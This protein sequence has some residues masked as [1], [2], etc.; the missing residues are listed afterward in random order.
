MEPEKRHPVRLAAQVFFFAV[1]LA[2]L[3]YA[4][5]RL[6][7]PITRLL[8]NPESFRRFL[9]RYGPISAL[10]YV[11][12]QVAQVVI[13]VIPGEVVQIAGGY[14]F[15]TA[16]GTLSSAA[17]IALGTL[18]VFFVTRLAGYPLVKIFVGPKK[19]AR[20]DFLVNDPKADITLFILF[21]IPGLPKDALVYISGLTPV[22]PW[23]FLLISTVARLP[24]LWGSAYIGAHLHQK[25]Y[26][27]VWILSA[28][29]LVLFIVGV[30][31][32]DR[33]IDR[34]RRMLPGGKNGP[35][36]G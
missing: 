32:K 9:D 17:G 12:I 29:A 8:K 33:I 3:V 4:S 11:L 25:D 27:A 6:G 19:L 5:I 24:G 22:K 26:L 34:L 14:V 2:V 36:A 31:T 13:A 7:P 23:K 28:A 1:F 15:G 21:L 10:V 30:L 16:V 35:Q 20:F 18:M